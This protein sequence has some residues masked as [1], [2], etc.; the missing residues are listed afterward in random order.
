MI[1]RPADKGGGVV[2]LDKDFYHGQMMDL[3]NV[4]AMYRNF[5]RDPMSTYRE[6]LTALI[7]LGSRYKVLNKKE[8]KYLL[9]SACRIPVIYTLPKVYKNATTPPP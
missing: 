5:H 4:R 9:P 7:E 6:Q 3:L 8:Q 1:I 2:V